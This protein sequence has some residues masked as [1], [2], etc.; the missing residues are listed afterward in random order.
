MEDFAGQT[1]QAAALQQR[2]S[3]GA[4][5]VGYCAVVPAEQDGAVLVGRR[6]EDVVTAAVRLWKE[7][8]S[9]VLGN[10]RHA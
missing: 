9:N 6:L 10:H 5:V 3:A 4:A 2:H 1:I 8:Q 7:V